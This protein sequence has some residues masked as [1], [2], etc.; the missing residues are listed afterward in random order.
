MPAVHRDKIDVQVNEQ[1]ALD[2]TFVYTQ[3]FVVPVA[4]SDEIVIVLGVVD[5]NNDQ[6]KIR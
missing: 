4:D 2:S 5:C 3:R 6:D 1:V